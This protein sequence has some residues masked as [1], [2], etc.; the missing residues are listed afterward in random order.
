MSGRVL[1]P[2]LGQLLGR[3]P[4]YPGAWMF[5]RWLNLALAPQLPG[6]VK[7]ALEGRLLR[8]G[9]RDAGLQFDFAWHGRRQRFEPGRAADRPDLLIAASLHDLWLLA[10]RREDPDTLFFSRRLVLEGDTEL[11]LLFKNTLDAIEGPALS[12][13]KPRSSR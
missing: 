9:V 6:D 3:L 8:L 2:P 4:R 11:A 5:S 7:A 13:F 12:L 10:M 1:P